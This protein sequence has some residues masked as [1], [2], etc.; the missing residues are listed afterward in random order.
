MLNWVCRPR[1]IDITDIPAK[2]C[3]WVVLSLTLLI[4]HDS[5][6]CLV[7]LA[8]SLAESLLVSTQHERD[9]ADIDPLFKFC[10]AILP[11]VQ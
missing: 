2:A 7:E 3:S 11:I 5:H 1:G 6:E 10:C 8:L 4:F 9:F